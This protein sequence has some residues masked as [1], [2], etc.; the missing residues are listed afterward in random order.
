MKEFWD[1]RYRSTEFAYGKNPNDLLKSELSE[2]T[3]GKALFPAEGE[4]RNAVYTARLGW[5]VTAFDQS[6]EGKNKALSLAREYDV[7]IN[8]IVSEMEDVDFEPQSFDLL[9]LVYAHFPSYLR[10]EY[11][12]KLGSYLKPGGKLILEGFAKG[13][14]VYQAKNPYAGG[15]RDISML[16][17]LPE[18]LADF[19]MLSIEEA[20]VKER[21]L[22]E[23][24]YHQ[25]AAWVAQFVATKSC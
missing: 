14:E 5:E 11:H 19:N 3:P 20:V 18:L 22:D 16:F 1:Q 4:G 25:G 21:I 24:P 6:S 10:R 12:Q 8:Y 17:S 2:L 7:S 13:H 9:V 23:G 15:P